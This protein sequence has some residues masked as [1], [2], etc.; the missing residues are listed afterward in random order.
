MTALPASLV[1]CMLGVRPP[2][3]KEDEAETP[4]QS[5]ERDPV[6]YKK[7]L[8]HW[9]EGY[10]ADVL[11]LSASWGGVVSVPK[12]CCCGLWDTEEGREKPSLLPRFLLLTNV[13]NNTCL[14]GGAWKTTR[15]AARLRE[16]RKGGMMH[17]MQSDTGQVWDSF[18]KA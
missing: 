2:S 17:T 16:G 12:S 6:A 8:G 11:G 5:E 7:A 4:H 13:C 1:E 10:M 9:L 14:G 3:I 18:A 15:Q